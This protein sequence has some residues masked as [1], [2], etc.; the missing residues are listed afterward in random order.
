VGNQSIAS[1]LH[2]SVRTVERHLSNCYA[3]LGL[4]GRTARA[5]AAARLAAHSRE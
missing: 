5:G 1:A 2:L 3:K 4:T